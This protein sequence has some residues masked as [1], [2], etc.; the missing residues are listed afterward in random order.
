MERRGV[1][2]GGRKAVPLL[3]HHVQQHRSLQTADHVQI[4]LQLADVVSVDRSDVAEAEVLEEHPSDQPGLDGVLHL[5]EEPLDRIADHGHAVEHF[6]HF[7]LQAGVELGHPQAVERLGHAAHS[8]TDR[9]LVV[10]EHDDEILFQPTGVVHGLEDHAATESAVAD[11]GHH[12]AVFLGPEQIVA[13]LQ[14][15]GRAHAAPGVA[16][17]KQVEV[18]FRRVGVAHQP[19]LGAHRLELVVPA[20]DHFVGVDL[21]ARVPDQAVAGKVERGMQGQSQLDHAQI[22]G[23]MGRSRGCQPAERLAH[24]AGQ[25]RQLLLR[26]SLQVG[27]RLNCREQLVHQ[28]FLSRTN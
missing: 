13:A 17:H 8:R 5:R 24:L 7:G 23:K 3:R 4:L 18:A 26:E 28:R 6:L 12:A 11:H 22:R 10:V 27:R 16:G 9:H 19:A 25:L 2:G 14:A 20:G 1:L 15:Q 21:M